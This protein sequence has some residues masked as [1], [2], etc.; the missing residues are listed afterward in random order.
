ME[1][2]LLGPLEV[3]DD[4]GVPVI[5]RSSRERAVLALLLLSPNR[6]V[7]SERLADDLWGD[8]PPEGAAHALQVNISR[9]RKALRDA[10][11]D[12]V[13]VTR[14]PGYLAEVDPDD[15]DAARFEALLAR[16]REESARGDHVNAAATLRQALGLW[17]GPALADFADEE[18]ARAAVARWEEQRLAALEA[19]AEARL[20]LGE[21]RDLAVDLSEAVTRHPYRERLRAAYL[22]ALYRAGRRGGFIGSPAY[23]RE[24]LKRYEEARLDAMIF[25]AQCGDR[26]HEDIMASI[27]LF[28]RTVLPDFK[29]RH[30]T[31]HKP[32]RER[33]LQ[34]FRYAMNSS[35]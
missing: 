9:L 15:V 13:L 17:R 8:R 12:D 19:Y 28:G 33:Q 5:L 34:D 1:F 32:W 4:S 23:I 3:L 24:N 30:E 2:R 27:D 14:S 22:R 26:R 35:I 29:E 18:F 21:H 20:E 11:A 10:G 16:S 7:S 6:V 31:Q 25:V